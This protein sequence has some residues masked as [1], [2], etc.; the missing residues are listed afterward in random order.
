MLVLN[1]SH[2]LTDEQVAQIKG[3]SG[4][5]TIVVVHNP[6]QIEHEKPLMPQIKAILD[7]ALADY[8]GG[9]II[10][11]PPG[12]AIAAVAVVRELQARGIEAQ[13]IRMKPALRGEVRVFEVVELI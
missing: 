5:N 13:Y 1:L 3:L 4:Q 2:P 9:S 8:K 6:V 12:L 10:V 11:N 7:V